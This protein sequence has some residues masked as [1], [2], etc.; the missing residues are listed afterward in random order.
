MRDRSTLTSR[1]RMRNFMFTLNNP[2]DAEKLFYNRLAINEDSRN[3]VNVRYVIFQ[4][5]IAP[6]TGTHHLQGYIELTR[7]LSLRQIRTTFGERGHYEVR[8]GSQAQAQDYCRKNDTRDPDGVANHGGIPARSRVSGSLVESIAAKATRSE[9]MTAYPEE[10]LKY[11]TNIDKMINSNVDKRT[12][13]MHTDIFFG[14]TGA[15]KSMTAQ[16]QAPEAYNGMWPCGGRWWWPDYEGEETVILDEFRHQ[17]KMDKMLKLLDRYPMK[18]EYKNGN[19]E[20][21]SKNIIITTNISPMEWYPNVSDRT[22]LR[23]RINEF[24]TV[25]KFE[26]PE[27]WDDRSHQ[28]VIGDIKKYKCTWNQAHMQYERAFVRDLSDD[29]MEDEDD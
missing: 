29:L 25:W 12:W 1:S 3:Q 28:K 21:R 15:G 22:M 7:Q 11:G 5:E 26:R 27:V 24:C 23:R 4:E 13:E 17:I 6:N 10:Y 16:H 9:I 2:T 19:T 14:E 8:R 20:F 18:I